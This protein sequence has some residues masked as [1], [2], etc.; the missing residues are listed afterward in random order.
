MRSIRRWL[1]HRYAQLR[2][3]ARRDQVRDELACHLGAAVE[4]TPAGARGRDS[5]YAVRDG[6]GVV[7]MLRL[8]NPHR[9]RRA[10]APEMPY[11]WLD[12]ESRLEREWTSYRRGSSLGLTPAP[13]W[14]CADALM[15]SYVPGERLSDVMH[16]DRRVFWRL[17]GQVAQRLARLHAADV[18]H[19]DS[20]LANV[21]RSKTRLRFIDFE[22]APASWV[23]PAQQRLFDHLKVVESGLKFLL[24]AELAGRDEWLEIL[25]E[26]LDPEAKA[27]DPRPLLP[28]LHWLTSSR[29]LVSDLHGLLPRIGA[30]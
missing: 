5:I 29:A 8:V 16:G 10:P 27:A 1:N 22:Y 26:C 2:I 23:T 13:V 20:C 18:T 3:R 30:P 21:L 9:Q 11:T 28:A 24:D 7:G 17:C 15:C 12:D 4:L 6:T 25:S 19:M 14:R